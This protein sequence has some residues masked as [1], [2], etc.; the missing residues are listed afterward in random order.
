[1]PEGGDQISGKDLI[2]KAAGKQ[3]AKGG[4]EP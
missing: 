1:M 2:L 3:E 4:K